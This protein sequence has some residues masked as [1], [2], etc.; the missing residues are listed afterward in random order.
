M[1]DLKHTGSVSMDSANHDLVLDLACDV[2]LCDMTPS[3]VR[4]DRFICV[5]LL[6][7]MCDITH[8]YVRDDS[9]ICV[10]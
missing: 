10:T 3:Y 4:R 5:T 6:I 1:K 7:H 2:T 9:F 8:S